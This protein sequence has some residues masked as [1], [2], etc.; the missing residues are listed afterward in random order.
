MHEGKSRGSGLESRKTRL[1]STGN[2]YPR[3]AAAATWRKRSR[4]ASSDQGT[5]EFLGVGAAG[6]GGFSRGLGGGAV[7]WGLSRSLGL[8]RGLEAWLG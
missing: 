8:S 1:V 3:A 7:A 6:H 4:H 5:G 2:G